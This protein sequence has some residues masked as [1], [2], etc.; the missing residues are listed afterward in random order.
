M[1]ID[2]SKSW[3]SL[4]SHELKILLKTEING[5]AV[6]GQYVNLL[7]HKTTADDKHAD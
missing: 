3:I 6:S 5:E 2:D 4:D 7:H 1:W